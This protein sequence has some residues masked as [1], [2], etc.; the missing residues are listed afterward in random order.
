MSFAGYLV[1]GQ[2]PTWWTLGGAAVVILSGLYV[3]ARERK[4]LGAKATG[5][6]SDIATQ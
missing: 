6:A 5:P 1:F 4:V 2:V 3:F